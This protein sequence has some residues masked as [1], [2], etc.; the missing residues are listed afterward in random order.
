MNNATIQCILLQESPMC[1]RAFRGALGVPSCI[2]GNLFLLLFI[3]LE[4]A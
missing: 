2:S 4:G 1:A 3:T